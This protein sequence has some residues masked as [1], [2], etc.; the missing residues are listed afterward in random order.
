MSVRELA[1]RIPAHHVVYLNPSGP[2]SMTV[3]TGMLREALERVPGSAHGEGGDAAPRPA[4]VGGNVTAALADD[5]M[6]EDG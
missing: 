6:T 4:T 1:E 3:E 5:A 2:V